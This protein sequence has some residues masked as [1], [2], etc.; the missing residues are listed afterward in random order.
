MAAEKTNQTQGKSR[1]LTP[2]YWKAGEGDGGCPGFWSERVEEKCIWGGTTGSYGKLSD[3]GAV[4]NL[5][6][7]SEHP[8]ASTITNTQGQALVPGYSPGTG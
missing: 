5:Y 3:R 4:H 7:H 2:G 8:H 1:S 6:S